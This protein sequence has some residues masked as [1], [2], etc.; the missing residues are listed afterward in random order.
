MGKRLYVSDLDGTLLNE[1]G[2]LSEFSVMQL[3]KLIA[4]GLHFTVASARSLASI[5]KLLS[6]VH[7]KLPVISFNG[8]YISD[9]SSKEHL[10]VN[11][12]EPDLAL[13]LFNFFNASILISTYN[14]FRDKLYS[15]G[16][17]NEGMLAY[18]KDRIKNIPEAIEE[19]EAFDFS[20]QI[21]AYT[22]IGERKE[23]LSLYQRLT[24]VFESKVIIDVWEDMYYKPWYWLSVHSN[25]STKARGLKTLMDLVDT[26]YDELVVFG[27][28]NND[29]EMF[30]VADQ[31]YAVENAIAALKAEATSMI[32]HHNSDSVVKHI[33]RMEDI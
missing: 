14:G 10:V 1:A 33:M 6:G 27:D 28:N 9:I 24:D 12:I 8:G 22:V 5:S 30:K 32:G 20:L 21:M 26:N 17:F 16:E 3:N 23:V 15:F 7:L 18:Q 11:A 29:L 2:E 25:T 13:E 4:Q 31:K 19:L